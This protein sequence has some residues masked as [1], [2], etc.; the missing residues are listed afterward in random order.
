MKRLTA[1]ALFALPFASF[2]ATNTSG[3]VYSAALSGQTAE[4][5]KVVAVRPV[6]IKAAPSHTGTYIGI[7]TAV[8]GA[9]GYA[10]TRHSSG[11]MRG[12]GTIVGGAAGAGAGTLLAGVHSEHPGVQIFVQRMDGSGR[13]VGSLT[14]VVQDDDQRIG[15]GE[16]VLLI[17]S[18]DGMS[19]A[20][21]GDAR[22]DT[23]VTP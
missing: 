8:G 11:S 21:A 18:R 23:E 15:V 20:P 14:S 3:R 10:L 4:L 2:A 6:E 16:T 12:L 1:L 5:A 17:R 22:A 19:I 7:G 13:P 9:A